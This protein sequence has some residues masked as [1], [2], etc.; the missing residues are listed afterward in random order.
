M[1]INIVAGYLVIF[2]TF[3]AGTK[4]TYRTPGA[5]NVNRS[6]NVKRPM[7]AFMVWAREYRPKLAN[8][9]PNSNNAEISIKLGQVWND[10]TNEEK[11]PFYEEAERIKTK[12]KLDHPGKKNAYFNPSTLMLNISIG[13][14]NAFYTLYA[15]I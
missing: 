8:Q 2:F 3:Q 11:K 5:S 4:M 9:L 7:N 12:H 10:L 1:T 14:Y 6:G 13:L 15:I